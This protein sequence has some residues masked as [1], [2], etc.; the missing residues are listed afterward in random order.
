ME[1]DI[2]SSRDQ[3]YMHTN[4]HAYIFSIHTSYIHTLEWGDFSCDTCADMCRA[5]R[6]AVTRVMLQVSRGALQSHLKIVFSSRKMLVTHKVYSR[7]CEDYTLV[8]ADAADQA[9]LDCPLIRQGGRRGSSIKKIRQQFIGVIVHA[10]GYLIYRRLPVRICS[11]ISCQII[12]HT[13]IITGNTQRR[14]SDHLY[15]HRPF[16][17]GFS[18]ENQDFGFTVGRFDLYFHWS[19]YFDFLETIFI[20]LFHRGQ[21]ECC[22]IKLALRHLVTNEEVW[23]DENYS[24]SPGSGAYA[25]RS[26]ST[27]RRFQS[28]GS[29]HHGGETKKRRAQSRY[30]YPHTHVHTHTCNTSTHTRAHSDVWATRKKSAFRSAAFCGVG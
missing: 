4:E 8:M 10:T 27:S 24:Q 11:C 6:N 7:R 14:E 19:I 2:K 30:M 17:T 12:I 16:P 21:W 1:F 9:K 22:Q 3:V 5:I 15:N 26:R 13:F 25:L 23:S 20:I 28:V 29:R 18:K